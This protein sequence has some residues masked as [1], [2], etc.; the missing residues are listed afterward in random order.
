MNDYGCLREGFFGYKTT[1]FPLRKLQR[2]DIRQSPAQR[3]AG[4]ANL[5]IH[6]ASHSITM[7][8]MALAEAQRFADL[9]LQQAESTEEGWF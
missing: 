6:L 7:P 9:A 1:L 2:A 5:T 4:L 8:Y 3:R